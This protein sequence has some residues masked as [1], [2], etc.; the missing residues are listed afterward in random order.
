M[1]YLLLPLID[2]CRSLTGVHSISG[3]EI[4]ELDSVGRTA[5]ADSTRLECLEREASVDQLMT[6]VC[7]KIATVRQR[8]A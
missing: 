8:G 1:Q 7:R 3:L 6:V 4:Q 2:S 5:V